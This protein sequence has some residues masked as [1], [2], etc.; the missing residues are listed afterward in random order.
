MIVDAHFHQWCLARD[1]Y[2]WITPDLSPIYRDFNLQHWRDAATD[3]IGGILVQCAPTLAETEYLLG[4]AHSNVDVLGVVGW[5]DLES[6]NAAAVLQRF[7]DTPKLVGIRPMIQDIADTEWMLRPAVLENLKLCAQLGLRFDALVLPQHLK[8][9]RK[10]HERVPDL[11]IV[12]DHAA[13]PRI[14]AGEIDAWREDMAELADAGLY[15]KLSGLLTEAESGAG[16][17]ELKP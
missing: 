10:L 12:I 6:A 5:V 1:D 14:T 15:C 16:I 2:G 11:A 13:K 8:V 9:L 7:A 17:V 4:I 3:V